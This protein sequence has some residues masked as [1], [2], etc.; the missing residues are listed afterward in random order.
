VGESTEELGQRKVVVESRSSFFNPPQRDP[1]P[2]TDGDIEAH[3]ARIAE[4]RAEMSQT[5]DCLQEKLNPQRIKNQVTAS[6]RG[7]TVGRAQQMLDNTRYGLMD[8]V[9]ANPI[10]AAMV[11]IGLGWLFTRQPDN[12][13]LY[14]EAGLAGRARDRMD[15]TRS[16]AQSRMEDARTMAQSRVDDAKTMAQS[17]VESAKTMAQSRM[18]DLTGRAQDTMSQ[19]QNRASAMTDQARYQATRARGGFEQ[20]LDENP[21][22]VGAIA[23][24]VGAAIGL[25]APT[26]SKENEVFGET[27]DRLMDRAQSTAQDAVQKAQQV[28]QK[29]ATTVQEEVRTQGLTS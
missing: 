25:S 3:K 20:M 23:L 1:E 21:L 13:Y 26:T 27:R 11:A 5:I 14:E 19:V 17:R 10:P 8:R 16:M 28:A 24:A 2:S 9:R 7:A 18:D 29:A 6:V 4:T 22:A 12:E 15:E